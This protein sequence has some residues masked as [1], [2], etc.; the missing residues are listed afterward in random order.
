MPQ[1]PYQKGVQLEYKAKEVM[2]SWF[3][4]YVVRSAGSHTPI[5]LLCGN[6]VNVYAAQIKSESSYQKLDWN[7]LRQ[8]AEAFQAIPTVLVHK[9]GG[10]WSIYFDGIQWFKQPEQA[11]T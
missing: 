5:D 1:T 9:K 6:G 7:V 2:E 11:I 3:G 4:C 10:I 8:W